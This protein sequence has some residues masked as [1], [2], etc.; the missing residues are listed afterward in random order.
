M[1]SPIQ[2]KTNGLEKELSRKNFIKTGGALVVGFSLAAAGLA[3]GRLA[4]AGTPSATTSLGGPWPTP[5]SLSLDSWLKIGQDGKV[6]A[7]GS[8]MDSGQGTGTAFSQ[9]IADEL[10]V[11]FESVTYLVGDTAMSPNNG[12]VGAAT[13]IIYN[14]QPLR[15]AAAEARLALLNLASARLGVPVG[16]LSTNNGV[17]SVTANPS[18]SVKYGDLV[19]G[20]LFNI[21]LHQVTLPGVPVRS[22]GVAFVS[23]AGAPV[24]DASQYKVIGKPIPRVDIP[25][26]VSGKYT[27]VQNVRV[28]EMVHARLVMPPSP[29]S[30]LVSIKGFR[31]GKP[32]GVISV[33]SQGNVVAVVAK[34]EWDAIHAA[35]TLDVVWSDPTPSLSGSGNLNGSLRSNPPVIPDQYNSR[36]PRA[37]GQSNN[38][39]RGNVDAALKSAAKVLEA[40]YF[41]PVHS[42]AMLA[43][44]C[45]VADVSDN[46]AVVFC[47]TQSVF[48]TQ[49]AVSTVTGIPVNN[50]RVIWKSGSGTYGRSEDAGPIAALISQSVGLPV[51]LQFMRWDDFQSDAYGVP[52]SYHLKGGVD[53]QNNVVAFSTEGWTWAIDPHTE[54]PTLGTM[55]QGKAPVGNPSSQTIQAFGGGDLN[56]YEFPNEA[57][58]FHQS[59]PQLRVTSGGLRS[60]KRIQN[61]FAAESFMDELASAVGMDPI[62]FRVQQIKNTQAL[63]PTIEPAFDPSHYQRQLAAIEGLRSMMKWE[64]RPSPGPGAK[65]SSNIVTGR[66]F[67]AMGNYTNVFGAMGAEVEVNK[68]TGRI[69]VTRLVNYVDPGLVINPLGAKSAVTQ[70]V[71]FALSRTLQEQLLFDKGK[72]VSRD[73]VTYPILR[74]VDVP[75]QE[76]TIVNNPQYWGGG[77]GEGNEIMVPAA[78]G[79]AVFDATGVRLRQVP[80]TP[81]KV[82]DA[83]KAAGVA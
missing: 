78:V 53:A 33:F 62:D 68:K 19:G 28:P 74:F 29:S 1:T 81:V 6:T 39:N 9:I 79:N 49:N 40:D 8:S 71:I 10:D 34:K 7:Y 35:G 41:F 66:G 56:T 57:W 55:L 22:G 61:N 64:S 82:K 27:Y 67:A 2:E 73:W 58:W 31:G 54:G 51:R 15:Y 13:G 4:A 63:I 32:E 77:L 83:L 59:H 16:Q 60:P 47:A 75:E 38:P 45:A 5:D 17:V 44:Y 36:P 18:Q 26:K 37:A 70:G 23:N 80:F 72:V 50:V 11:P 12:S 25:D 43:P 30:N 21:P 14:S 3:P 48:G 46:Q 76:V 20:K 42:H 24:K 69:R 52:Y 65:S